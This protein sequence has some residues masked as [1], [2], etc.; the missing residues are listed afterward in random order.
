MIAGVVCISIQ[1]FKEFWSFPWVFIN[2]KLSIHVIIVYQRHIYTSLSMYGIYAWGKTK[3]PVIMDNW[4]FL[5]IYD[6]Y[7]WQAS[8][9]YK[10]I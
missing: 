3:A 1:Q 5:Y 2:Q 6:F 7:R 8:P 10:A 9:Q 4:L